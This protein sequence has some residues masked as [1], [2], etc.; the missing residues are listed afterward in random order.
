MGTSEKGRRD[1][2]PEHQVTTAPRWSTHGQEWALT[3]VI[4]GTGALVD[5]VGSE[6]LLL[7]HPNISSV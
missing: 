1:S 2:S 3:A 5:P 7:I 4:R 6:L